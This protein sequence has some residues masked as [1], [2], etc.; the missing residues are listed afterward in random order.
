MRSSQM[1]VKAIAGV[2]GAVTLSLTVLWAVSG[3]RVADATGLRLQMWAGADFQGAPI[4]DTISSD[5]VVGFIDNDRTLPR[6]HFSVRWQGYW[7]VPEARPVELR[8]DADDRL[9]VWIDDELV[10]SRRAPAPLQVAT[11]WLD[12]GV[13]R[14]PC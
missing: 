14:V 7:Y 3:L 4:L 9:D 12:A 5:V 1:S 11:A 8:G 13:P 10:I 2:W 6:R